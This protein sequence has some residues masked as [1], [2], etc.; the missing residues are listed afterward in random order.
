MLI[1]TTLAAPAAN[2]TSLA[3]EIMVSYCGDAGFDVDW[4]YST[5]CP[6]VD[7]AL[8]GPAPE[9]APAQERGY[10]HQSDRLPRQ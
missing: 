7:G 10:R 9:E 1:Y 5:F 6:S 3:C 8:D 2:A 4:H